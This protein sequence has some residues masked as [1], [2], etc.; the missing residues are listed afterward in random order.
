MDPD[1][2]TNSKVA[3]LIVALC[4]LTLLLTSES[5]VNESNMAP[6]SQ[7]QH[8]LSNVDPRIGSEVTHTDPHMKPHIERALQTPHSIKAQSTEYHTHPKPVITQLLGFP[9]SGQN[10][11]HDMVHRLTHY[12][13]ATVYGNGV[14]LP[15]GVIVGDSFDSVPLYLG[16]EGREGPYAYSATLPFPPKGQVMTRTHCAGHCV[17]CWPKDYVVPSVNKWWF[18]CGIGTRYDLATDRNVL[19]HYDVTDKVHK[20]IHMVRDPF[21]HIPARFEGEHAV[22]EHLNMTEELEMYPMN[23]QGFV[24]WCYDHDFNAGEGRRR[25]TEHEYFLTTPELLEITTK[26]P[27]PT[28]FFRLIQWHNYMF[29]AAAGIVKSKPMKIIYYEEVKQNPRNVMKEVVSFL[30]QDFDESV[31]L[32]EMYINLKYDGEYITDEEYDYIKRYWEI[33]GTKSTWNHF[34]ARYFPS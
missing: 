15:Q 26:F 17:Q 7:K 23:R 14:M 33:L 4:G 16:E 5:M 19:T 2:L 13:T 34:K 28:D 30:D 11:I 20:N 9:F 25:E 31:E 1:R 18:E 8:E 6:Q 24:K 27:C 32:P 29:E 21:T 10:Y 12:S 3:L 22:W